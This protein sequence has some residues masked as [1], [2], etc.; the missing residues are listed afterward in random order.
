[1]IIRFTINNQG[2]YAATCSNLGLFI[3]IYNLNTESLHLKFMRGKLTT[4]SVYSICFNKTSSLLATTHSSG[5]VKIFN[6]NLTEYSPKNKVDWVMSWVSKSTS[7]KRICK[8]FVSKAET[9]CEFISEQVLMGSVY[10][11]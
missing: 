2:T 5:Y 10:I 6:T 9:R 3:K 4:S 8:F 7:N 11:N 1:M